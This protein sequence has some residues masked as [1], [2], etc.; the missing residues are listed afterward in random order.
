MALHR[1]EMSHTGQCVI[2]D[3]GSWRALELRGQTFEME[4]D[5]QKAIDHYRLAWKASY[6][7]NPAIGYRYARALMNN[8]QPVEAIDICHKV[9]AVSPEY[10]R[11]KEM[12]MLPS[13]K[14]I[15]L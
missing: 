10:P 15:R 14:L 8:K 11:I 3:S 6:G 13:R 2:L 9:L 5:V 12:I 1:Q 4:K 7:N